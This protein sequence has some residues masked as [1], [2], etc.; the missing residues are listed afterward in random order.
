[1]SKRG[2]LTFTVWNREGTLSRKLVVPA[3]YDVCSRCHGHGTHDHPAFSNGITASEWYGPDWDDESRETYMS[4]GY[5]V[6]CTRCKGERVELVPD[7][8]RLTKWQVA[9]LGLHFVGVRRDEAERES[10]ERWGY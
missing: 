4:G 3:V 5:D 9:V 10:E 8:A 2:T 7:E 6:T 1:M